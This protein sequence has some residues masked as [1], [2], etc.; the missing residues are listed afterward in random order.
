MVSPSSAVTSETPSTSAAVTTD[1]APSTSFV[2]SPTAS[3]VSVPSDSLSVNTAVPTSSVIYETTSSIPA[4][5]TT[6]VAISQPSPAVAAPF[7]DFLDRNDTESYIDTASSNATLQQSYAEAESAAVL[8]GFDPIPVYE[9]SGDFV[10]S[11]SISGNLILDSKDNAGVHTWIS[12]GG[13]IVG[14]NAR[15][16]L[17]YYPDEM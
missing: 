5:T 16:P 3:A 9:L 14:A 6:S 15:Y 7:S 2:A 13:I 17:F 11:S 4:S 12:D 10:L 1:A 8:E